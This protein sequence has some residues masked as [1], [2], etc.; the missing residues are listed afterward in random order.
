MPKQKAGPADVQEAL[1]EIGRA[2]ESGDPAGYASLFTPDADYTAFDG[3]RMVG[4][5]E[6]EE[7]H[8][9]LFAGIMRGS[10]MTFET[11]SIRHVRDDVAV[12]AVRGGIIMRWQKNRTSP[13]P[14][15]LS[16]LSFL[17]VRQDDGTWLA[18]L[19]HNTRYRPWNKTVL[20]RLVTRFGSNS[21]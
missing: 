10:R 14:K 19:F 6:I 1:T 18:T 9:A 13:S 2:W 12:V 7:G 5:S 17:F 11:P 8:R 16:S 21:Q 3:T 4:R 15:R 20:G